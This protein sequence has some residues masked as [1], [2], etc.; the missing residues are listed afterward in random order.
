MGRPGR[1]ATVAEVSDRGLWWVTE[2]R[3]E[4]NTERSP[5]SD[6]RQVFFLREW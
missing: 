4:T 6:V 2:R 3:C 5:F 1:E